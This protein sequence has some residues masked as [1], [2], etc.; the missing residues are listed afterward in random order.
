MK[1][2]DNKYEKPEIEVIEIRVEAGIA[3]SPGVPGPIT[4]DPDPID[5]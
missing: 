2:A 4:P 3:Q 1:T 5:F